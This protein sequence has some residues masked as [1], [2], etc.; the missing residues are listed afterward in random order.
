MIVVYVVTCV[1]GLISCMQ[2][3]LKT[4]KAPVDLTLDCNA[5]RR[6]DKNSFQFTSPFMDSLALADV[7]PKDC[8]VN[9]NTVKF[10]K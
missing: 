9:A 2:L 5:M 6:M 3:L 4:T 10:R 7:L 1:V 8:I